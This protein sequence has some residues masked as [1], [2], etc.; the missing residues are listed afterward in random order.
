MQTTHPWAQHV[1][2]YLRR[3]GLEVERSETSAEAELTVSFLP[4]ALAAPGD[5]PVPTLKQVMRLSTRR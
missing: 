4:E 3:E 1:D 2:P 5:T